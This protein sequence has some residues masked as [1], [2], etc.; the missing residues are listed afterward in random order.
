MKHLNALACI[1]VAICV[2]HCG[3]KADSLD[4]TTENHELALYEAIEA[5]NNAFQ[6][7]DVVA[8]ES[9]ITE[10]YLH[11][12]GNSK[13]IQKDSWLNYLL[14]RQAEIN[15]GNLQVTG[16][17]MKEMEVEFYG[18]TAVVTG[19]ISVVSKKRDSIHKN[20]YRV[21]HLWINE[22]GQWKRA[23]FHDGRIQ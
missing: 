17:N 19:K 18:N 5:F 23:A 21:T 20:A 2:S 22:S 16:Y 9:M 11:T 10:N 3:E 12:N 15:S 1:I 7:G 13:S 6:H 14:K 4:T 8:I